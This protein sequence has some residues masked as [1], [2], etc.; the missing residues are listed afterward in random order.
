VDISSCELDDAEIPEPPPLVGSDEFAQARSAAA[1][2]FIERLEEFFENPLPAN[3]RE[4]L[5]GLLIEL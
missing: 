2:V 5:A 1:I 3:S 4:H